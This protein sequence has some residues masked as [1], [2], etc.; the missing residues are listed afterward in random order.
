M[1]QEPALSREGSPRQHLSP[2]V[3]WGECFSGGGGFS[4]FQLG[5]EAAGQ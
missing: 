4:G 3:T 2:E 1:T 5:E